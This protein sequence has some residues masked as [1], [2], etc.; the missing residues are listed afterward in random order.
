MTASDELPIWMRPRPSGVGRPAQHSREEIT[1]AAVALADAAGL[2]AVSM[3]R[4]AAD[5]GTGA[6]SLY[7]YV[8]TRDDLLDLMTDA[9]AAEYELAAPSGDWLGDL[10]A[11]GEQ[12]RAILRRHPWL[13]ALGLTRPALGP[14][15]IALLQHAM[16]LLAPCPAG[17]AAKAE[18]FAM[19]NG[20]T[21]TFVAHEQAGGSAATRRMV[22]YLQHVLATGQYPRLAELM[23]PPAGPPPDPADRYP[24]I[25][26]RILAG[27]LD[28]G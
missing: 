15:A 25:M 28:G 12:I 3:R 24:E 7:R 11:L 20:I 22:S 18:A 4:V 16:E 8:D 19:L 6:A 13:V 9:V 1:A 26:R 17:P 14:N 21:T 27:L 5:L 23:G 10:V 2:D